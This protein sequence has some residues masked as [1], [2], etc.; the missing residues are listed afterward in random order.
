MYI[1]VIT[2]VIR[3]IYSI[4]QYL[5]IFYNNTNLFKKYNDLFL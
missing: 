2:I 5:C 1:I 3:K 4:F